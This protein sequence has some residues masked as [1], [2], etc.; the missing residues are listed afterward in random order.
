MAVV[1]GVGGARDAEVV[2][3]PGFKH[4]DIAIIPCKG[5][6]RTQSGDL[7]QP[8]PWPAAEID[9]ARITISRIDE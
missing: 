4:R 5:R 3:S 8:Q 9:D 2:G 1:S 7:L 6:V